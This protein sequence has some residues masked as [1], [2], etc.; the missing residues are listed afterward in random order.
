[1]ATSASAA[2]SPAS[3]ASIVTRSWRVGDVRITRVVE[4]GGTP[5]PPRFLFG[6]IDQA[7]IRDRPW[8]APRFATADG[9]ILAAIQAFVIESDGKVIIVDTCLGN[10]KP[11]TVPLFDRLQTDFL[12]RLAGAGFPPERI[13]IVLCTHLHVDHVGWNTRLLDE[14]WRPTFPNARYLFGRV[15]W[16][17]WS[18]GVVNG[19]GDVIGDSVR[20]VVE[21]GLADLVDMDHRLTPEV[22]LLPTPGHTPGHVSV[23]IESRGCAAVITGDVIHHP[24]QCC[25]PDVDCN[26]DAD[27]GAA[28][29][30]RRTFLARFEN[31]AVAIFGTHFAHPTA[32]WIRRAGPTW[33]FDVDD[34]ADDVLEVTLSRAGRSW[35]PTTADCPSGIRLVSGETQ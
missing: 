18:N 25:D 3:K 19:D 27:H 29:A 21:A 26:F 35:E 24:V 12:D 14:E 13:D 17:Y 32:G 33:R 20:P 22:R 11:R 16:E 4:L 15:E 30:A 1:M 8:L 34:T 2:S 28:R 6:S 5:T 9:Q 7:F 23:M 10:G 31:T